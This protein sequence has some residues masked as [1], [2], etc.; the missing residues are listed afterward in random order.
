M[1]LEYTLRRAGHLY[2]ERRMCPWS[3]CGG[4]LL[5]SQYLCPPGGF[6]S[7]CWAQRRSKA[8]SGNKRGD[9]L[10]KGK[11]TICERV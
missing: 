4:H 1:H 2:F 7:A 3:V 11:L 9:C 5:R 8:G 10:A 6:L